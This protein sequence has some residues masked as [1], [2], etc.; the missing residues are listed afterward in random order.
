MA[1]MKKSNKMPNFFIIGA[2]KCG[3]T[4]L[5]CWL[6]EHPNIFLTRPKEPHFFSTDLG[7]SSGMT[8]AEYLKLFSSVKSHHIRVGEASTWYLFSKV[9]V[10]YIEAMIST[11]KYIVVV[12]NPVELAHS[13]FYHNKRTFVEDAETFYE[14]LCLHADRMKLKKLPSKCKEPAFVQYLHAARLGDQLEKLF[15]TV[16]EKRILLISL[17]ELKKNPRAAYK[18]ALDFL[19]LDDDGRSAFPVENQ[20]RLSRSPKV[21]KFIEK[22]AAIKSSLGIKRSFGI[23]RINE[24]KITKP[25]LSEQER[26]ILNDSLEK[27]CMI[28]KNLMDYN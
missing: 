9:A 3:T 6:R 7:N 24:T 11:P 1:V 5:S 15:V 4:S 2:P 21:R 25:E 26:S 28:I 10:P 12:R 17:G 18:K 23:S 27:Q 8:P 20:A 13:L 14:A 16:P 19:D 22:G